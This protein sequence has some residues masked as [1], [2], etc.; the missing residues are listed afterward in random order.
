MPPVFLLSG[1][2]QE[3][4]DDY[5]ALIEQLGGRMSDAPHYEASSTHLV[6]GKAILNHLYA[7][8]PKAASQL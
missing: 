8:W 3:E 2:S 1:M 5:G 7:Q 6:V 4:R